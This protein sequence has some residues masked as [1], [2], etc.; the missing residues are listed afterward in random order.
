MPAKFS[1]IVPFF[2]RVPASHSNNRIIPPYQIRI[3][4]WSALVVLY[5]EPG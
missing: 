2:Q 3:I 1:V 4:V 5:G